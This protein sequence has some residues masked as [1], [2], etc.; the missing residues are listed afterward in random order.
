VGGAFSVHF[1]TTGFSV[2]KLLLISFRRTLDG[3]YRKILALSVSFIIKVED[4]SL[5]ML[6]GDGL[7][8]THFLH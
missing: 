1:T 2:L 6:H 8:T 3:N 5:Y 4:D 7:Y